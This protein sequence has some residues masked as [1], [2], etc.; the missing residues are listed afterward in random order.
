MCLIHYNH[1]AV[2]LGYLNTFSKIIIASFKCIGCFC[3]VR[4]YGWSILA[5]LL[6][7]VNLSCKKCTVDPFVWIYVRPVIITRPLRPLSTCSY[8]NRI[9]RQQLSFPD[10]RVSK[11]QQKALCHYIRHKCFLMS[12]LVKKDQL[13][14]WAQEIWARPISRYRKYTEILCVQH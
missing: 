10:D 14:K 9:T 3:K 6:I 13:L 12:S 2:M 4:H 7:L 8:E 5:A 1:A 11:R